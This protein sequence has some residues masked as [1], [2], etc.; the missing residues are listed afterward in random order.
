MVPAAAKGDVCKGN[1]L[2]SVSIGWL[3]E[4]QWELFLIVSAPSTTAI[5]I[6]KRVRKV[7]IQ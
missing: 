3:P 1:L 7:W 2:A 4:C 6:S 5:L